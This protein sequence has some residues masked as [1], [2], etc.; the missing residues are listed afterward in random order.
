MAGAYDLNNDATRV[1]LIDASG[2]IIGG[3]GQAG[4][5]D[6]QA[7]T[8]RGLVTNA[9]LYGYDGAAWDRLRTKG[10]GWQGVTLVRSSD[11]NEYANSLPGDGDSASLQSLMAAA[12]NQT[13]NGSTWD[14]QRGNVEGTLLAS[15]A[16]TATTTS[17][18]QTNYNARGVLVGI[19]VTVVGTGNLTPSIRATDPVSADAYVLLSGGPITTTGRWG[20]LVYPGAPTVAF[21]ASGTVQSVGLALPRT[22]YVQVTHSDGSGWTYSLSFAY[23][24]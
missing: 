6:A 7:A 17:P 13:Y 4:N 21:G 24:V 18:T 23:V 16:R 8:D 20:F 14:R 11:G 9:R 1:I 15:A 3:T 19:S 12:R 22:W 5:A 10:T 2:N